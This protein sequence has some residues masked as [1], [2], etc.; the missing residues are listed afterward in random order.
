[1]LQTGWGITV[2]ADRGTALLALALAL[3][4]P[5]AAQAESS[6]P[7][8]A[9]VQSQIQTGMGILKNK[10]LSAAQQRDQIK[11]FLLSLLDTKRIALF[12]LG[13]AQKTVTPADLATYTDA[14]RDF[15]V[16]SYVSRLTGYDGQGLKVTGSTVNGPGDYVVSAIIVDP[17][18]P[19]GAQEPEVDLRVV[20]EG[21]TFFVVD[22]S[23][24]GIWLMLAQHDDF[25]GYLKLHN[26]D[27]PAL[28]IH[29]KEMTARLLAP[30]N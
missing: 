10:G 23:I 28:T 5:A 9:Y 11:T 14:F 29:L 4:F 7:A 18:D 16:A 15:M 17:N 8:E 22:A 21:G 27:V 25:A 6:A 1:M 24:E 20:D 13:A 2:V 3:A 26:N 30:A 19:P 12:T